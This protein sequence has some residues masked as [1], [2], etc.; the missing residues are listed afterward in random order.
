MPPPRRWRRPEALIPIAFLAAIL[1]GTGLLLLPGMD[2][3]GAVGPLEALFTATSAVC[4]TGLVVVDTGTDLTR[5]GQAVVL[6]LIQAGGLGIA[7]FS[8]LALAVRR[9]VAL[10]EEAVLREAFT[11]IAHW[12]VARVLLGVVTVTLTLEAIGFV[13]LLPS[14]GTWSALF[15]SVSATCNAGF[16]LYRN[17]LQSQGPAVVVPVL[18]LLVLGGLGFVTIAE[19]L[20]APF[21][22]RGSRRVSLHTRIVLLASAVLLVLGT[23]LVMLAEGGRPGHA[24]F[25]SASA[26]TA[27]FDT[28]PVETLSSASLLSLI[29]LMFVGG[30]PGSTAG[31]IKTTTLAVV[32]L[33]MQSILR[34]RDRITV[35]GRQVPRAI[36]RRSFAVLIC[37]LIVVAVAIFALTLIE[38]GRG[39]QFLPIA[40][41]VV[42]AFGT[43]G[44][45]AGLTTDLTPASHVCLCLVMFVGRVGSLSFFV[46]LVRE[47]PDSAVRYPEEEV[48][49]G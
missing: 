19:L 13:V 27:G 15:H 10:G 7:S 22:S 14:L 16:S 37:S 12:S 26:R 24:F 48:L 9:P 20:A 43:V 21:R 46:L 38:E 17:S 29:F 4:V 2:R 18:V 33:L 39:L 32:G 3:G 41:E 36:L 47:G 30:S 44:L 23:L 25:L 42:S 31:G 45:S 5:L 34:G 8:I 11:P 35:F 40:F 49:V 6:L 28:I 1:V